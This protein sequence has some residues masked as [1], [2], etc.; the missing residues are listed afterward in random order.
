MFFPFSFPTATPARTVLLLRG[1]YHFVLLLLLLRRFLRCLFTADACPWLGYIGEA[2]H[3]AFDAVLTLIFV[4]SLQ[5]LSDNHL[6]AIAWALVFMPFL[7][8]LL[9]IM[10]V[11]RFA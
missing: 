6:G 2:I 10:H 4:W 3:I 7:Y 11:R 8:T 9:G 5:F 1:L